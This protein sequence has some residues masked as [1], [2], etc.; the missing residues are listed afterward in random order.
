MEVLIYRSSFDEMVEH[1]R[2][3]YP[4]EACGLLA[5]KKESSITIS[6]IY[7]T[8]N[9]SKS[10]S[11]YEIDPYEMYDALLDAEGKG[12]EIVGAYHSH[13]LGRAIPSRIDEER[14]HPGFLYIIISLPR[15]RVRAFI[16]E[17]GFEELPIKIAG[18]S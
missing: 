5:G 12:L 3:E 11:R 9:I 16:W 13:P 17:A 4:R 8:S 14:A 7:R 2:R 15:M 10:T 6:R 1:A 18:T